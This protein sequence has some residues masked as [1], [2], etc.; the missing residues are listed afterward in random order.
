MKKIFFFLLLMIPVFVNA[1]TIKDLNVLNGTL[2]RKFEFNNN[3]YSIVLEN[4]ATRVLFD[5][6]L[7]NEEDII[8]IEND[9]YKENEENIAKIKLQNKEGMIEEYTFYLEKENTTPVFQNIDIYNTLDI[10]K[11][12]PHLEIYV[13]IGC[14]FIICILFKCIVLGFKKK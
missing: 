2:S 13:G 12:I 11:E 3:I 5:F 6:T 8:T 7:E 14:L 10:K 9:E 1:G 4:D